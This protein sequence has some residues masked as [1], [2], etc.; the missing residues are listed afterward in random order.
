MNGMPIVTVSGPQLS[1]EQKRKM[2]EGLTEVAAEVYGRPQSQ[3]IVVINENPPENV[4][5][6]GRLV[7]D[8]GGG[9]T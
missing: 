5:V 6:G 1:V 4:A 3:I 7:A 2:A 9:A 8:R